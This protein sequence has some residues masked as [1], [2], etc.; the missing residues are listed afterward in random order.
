MSENIQRGEEDRGEDVS[1]LS[2][3]EKK[4]KDDTTRNLIY[5]S[6]HSNPPT[7]AVRLGSFPGLGDRIVNFLRTVSMAVLQRKGGDA[8]VVD[9]SCSRSSEGEK[10]D[11]QSL[12]G[13]WN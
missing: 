10:G 8:S 11:G 12:G 13:A 1:S 4:M 2:K 9:Q 5:I 3:R 7:S 6:C